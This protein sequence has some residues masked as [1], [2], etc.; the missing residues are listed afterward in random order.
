M[1]IV[2]DDWE[3]RSILRNATM[4]FNS[5]MSKNCLWKNEVFCERSSP[6]P[7]M[8]R[9]KNILKQDISCKNA[10]NTTLD[11]SRPP[12]LLVNDANPSR[13]S[14]KRDLTTRV[15][16]HVSWFF[17]QHLI[18]V[19]GL[20]ISSNDSVGNYIKSPKVQII[21]NASIQC[22]RPNQHLLE[23]SFKCCKIV[24]FRL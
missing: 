17:Y 5:Q 19:F 16:R 20:F 3:G 11:F 1:A 10:F 23:S 8:H 4:A 14:P 6:A 7:L 13:W 2:M 21:E 9:I 15:N 12:I 18:S 24:R 22:K